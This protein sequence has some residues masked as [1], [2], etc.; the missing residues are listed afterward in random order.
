MAATTSPQAVARHP[1]KSNSTSASIPN[2]INLNPIIKISGIKVPGITTPDI[3]L[4][5]N[6]PET[7]QANPGVTAAQTENWRDKLNS[8]ALQDLPELSTIAATL[9][10][11]N[12]IKHSVRVM[13]K[14]CC[15][16][17]L[18]PDPRTYD[19]EAML[20]EVEMFRSLVA[21]LSP[22]AKACITAVEAY[23]TALD[24][25]LS[26]TMSA[27]MKAVKKAKAVQ[28]GEAYFPATCTMATLCHL[29]AARLHAAA[30]QILEAL[31]RHVVLK[32]WRKDRMYT[33]YK[34]VENLLKWEDVQQSQTV[35]RYFPALLQGG[36]ARMLLCEGGEAGEEVG[37]E[38]GGEEEV[39]LEREAKGISKVDARTGVVARGNSI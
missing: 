31:R 35:I 27:H 8:L 33:L 39:D 32:H 37:E 19:R 16:A 38:T 20:A 17:R 12:E 26:Q 34:T 13:D 6:P 1:S 25:I 3:N 18:W 28:A 4:Y 7:I 23:I 2:P 10:A 9:E 30:E 14:K 22:V 11:L 24:D 15:W 5:Y 29:T 36:E 21:P